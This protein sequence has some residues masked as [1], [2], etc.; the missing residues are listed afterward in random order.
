M[1]V[2]CVFV[3]FS[4]KRKLFS[5]DVFEFDDITTCMLLMMC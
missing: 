1:A 5:L 2:V 4:F 3:F